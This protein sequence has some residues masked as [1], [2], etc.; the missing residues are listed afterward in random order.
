MSAFGSIQPITSAH[1]KSFGHVEAFIIAN[2]YMFAYMGK[3]SNPAYGTLWSFIIWYIFP[4]MYL[5][6]LQ[7]T[8]L[9]SSYMISTRVMT[10]TSGSSSVDC[11]FFFSFRGISLYRWRGC[12]SHKKMCQINLFQRHIILIDEFNAAYNQ[13]P[14]FNQKTLPNH[15]DTSQQLFYSHPKP[16]N[17]EIK[18][19]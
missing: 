18:K 15:H 7:V 11:T 1:G 3:Y 19:N 13:K 16:C 14:S 8:A 10:S 9:V 17:T 5:G 6:S 4:H 2:L 12:L